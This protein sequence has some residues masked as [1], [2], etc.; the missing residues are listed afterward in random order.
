MAPLSRGYLLLRWYH[1][2]PLATSFQVLMSYNFPFNFKN[3][4]WWFSS[5][6][7]P[8]TNYCIFYINFSFHG[9]E[10]VITITHSFFQAAL[11]KLLF[12]SWTEGFLTML[13]NRVAVFIIPF[14][15]LVIFNTYFLIILFITCYIARIVKFFIKNISSK[16]G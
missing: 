11:K 9:W 2:C 10:K 13:T 3:N 15:T 7:K 8:C 16:K 1:L 14:D 12:A 4:M 5:T 6:V